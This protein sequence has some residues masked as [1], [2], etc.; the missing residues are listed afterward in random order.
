MSEDEGAAAPRV[1]EQ[2]QGTEQPQ[3]VGRDRERDLV[4]GGGYTSYETRL[5]TVLRR[6]GELWRT[7]TGKGR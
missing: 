3:G 4:T 5:A 6:L 7:L 2:S 1:V